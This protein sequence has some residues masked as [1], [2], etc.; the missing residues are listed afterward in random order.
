[1]EHTS[2]MISASIL[3]ADFSCLGNQI[4]EVEKAGVDWLHLDIMDGHFVPNISMGSFIV[5]TCK[6]ISSL[7]LDTHL[8]IENPDDYIEQF[9]KAGSSII[10]VHI[11]NNRH[12]NRTLQKIQDLNC[13][14]GIALNPGTPAES[15]GS[16]IDFVDLVLIMT[17]N[18]GFG[19]QA[20]IK[21]QINKIEKIKR[22]IDK[23]THQPYLE[24]DGGLTP[25]NLPIALNSGA[26]V[27]VIGSAIFSNKKGIKKSV[28]EIRS[29]LK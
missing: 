1:M 19:G 12:I 2:P 20:F 15:I 5:E 25:Q 4:N 18:P 29:C 28:E 10:S 9:A 6:R 7:P 14:A 26:N 23:L 3:N 16:I 17:V 24:I 11:E 27:F 8:M 21:N 13:K 22:M